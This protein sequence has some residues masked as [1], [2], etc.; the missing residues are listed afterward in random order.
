MMISVVVVV[1]LCILGMAGAGYAELSWDIV[2]PEGGEEDEAV[3]V[4]LEHLRETGRAHEAAFQ[5]VAA[6]NPE[7]ARTILVGSPDRNPHVAKYLEVGAVALE[8]V[9]DPQG[10]Q[11]AT[12]PR[13]PGMTIVVAG[14]SLIGDVYGLYWVRD[15]MRVRGRMEPIDCRH[16]PVLE[17]RYTRIRVE[18][19]EDIQRALSYRLNL[20]YGETPLR[21]VPW[22]SE[23]EAAENEGHRAK[24]KEL[25]EY[26][27]ALHMKFMPFGTEFTFHPSLIEEFGARLSPS[28]PQL[29]EA[30]K[31][32]Y[33]RLFE[34]LPEIDG[35]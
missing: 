33:R 4:C 34:A 26:A 32:K 14:G 8:E 7:A 6:P 15:R 31:A 30:L 18:S 28:D 11:I 22:K 19:K 10:Y 5:V 24:A 1:F 35:W 16:A 25:A 2:L 9:S 17:T 27:H 20:V 3:R 21:L 12:V 13:N 29:W 23:A